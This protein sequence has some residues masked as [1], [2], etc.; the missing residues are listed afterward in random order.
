MA[1]KWEMDHG[2]RYPIEGFVERKEAMGSVS[3]HSFPMRLNPIVYN[4]QLGVLLCFIGPTLILDDSG[5]F[6]VGIGYGA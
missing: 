6:Q 5:P 4:R 3:L 1:M 2:D